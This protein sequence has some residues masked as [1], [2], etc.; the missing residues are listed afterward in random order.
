MCRNWANEATG[1]RQRQNDFR[2]MIA[3]DLLHVAAGGALSKGDEARD[4]CHHNEQY[5]KCRELRNDY[6]VFR[7][8]KREKQRERY[9]LYINWS[10]IIAF[11]YI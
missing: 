10:K 6:Q 7:A 5:G 11:R 3:D 9:D 2:A 1:A 4:N 8:G